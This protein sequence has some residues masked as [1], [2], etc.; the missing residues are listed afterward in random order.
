V[1]FKLTCPGA[2]GNS[3]CV[4][5][6]VESESDTLTGWVAGLGV[7][8]AFAGWRWRADYRYADM[9]DVDISFFESTPVDQI[10][11]NVEVTSQ[12]LM[13]SLIRPF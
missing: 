9:G 7:E 4:A 11:G 10:G 8:K 2:A 6:R 13:V 5:D 12:T 1:D 3:W